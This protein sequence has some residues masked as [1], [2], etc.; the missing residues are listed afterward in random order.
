[1]TKIKDILPG[2]LVAIMVAIISMFLGKFV[3]SLGAASIARY[4]CW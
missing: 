4:V 2:L 1:M 3:P